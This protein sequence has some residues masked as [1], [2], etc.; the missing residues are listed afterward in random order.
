MLHLID[1]AEILMLITA[2]VGC[3]SGIS[4]RGDHIVSVFGAFRGGPAQLH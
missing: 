1:I 4:S 2:A 3:K